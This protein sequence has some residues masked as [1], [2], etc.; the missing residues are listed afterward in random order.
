MAV[1]VG[2]PGCGTLIAKLGATPSAGIGAPTLAET[3]LVLTARLGKDARPVVARLLQEANLVVIP[4]GEDHWPAAVQAYV[5][6]GKGRHAAGLNFGDC[7]THPVP[8]P[9]PPPF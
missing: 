9:P 1:V 5:R 8:H 4:F 7:P 2:E 6:F 3:G